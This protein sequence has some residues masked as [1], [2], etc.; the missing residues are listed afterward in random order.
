MHMSALNS[1]AIDLLGLDGKVPGVEVDA[2]G[3][4]TGIIKE[5][6][7]NIVRDAT[8]PDKAK[9]AKA[10]ALAT[11][12]AHSMGVTSVQDNGLAE[13]LSV[14]QAA[15]RSGKLGLRV[16]FNVPARELDPML[17][18]SISSGLGSNFLR[19]GGVKLFCDG[20]LGARTAALSE[21]YADDAGNRGEFMQGREAL[22]DVVAR[23][24]SADIQLV[25]HAIGDMGIEAAISS[26]ESALEGC[27]RRDH[28]H[29]IEHLEL[30]SPKHLR[31]MRKSKIIASMQP[32]FVGE[33]GGTNGMYYARL[34]EAR[35]RRNNP[36]KEVLSSGVRMVFGSDCMPF[37]PLYGIVSA[38]KAPHDAQR[39]TAEEAV[40][41]Y[42]REAAYASFE[43]ASKGTVS[44]GKLA[45]LAI[46]SADPFVDEGA[47]AGA[48]VLKTV[49]GGDV[50]YE[51][52]RAGE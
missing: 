27:P 5:S 10:L 31:R 49:V 13:H 24:N 21:P 30:P 7:V 20:A 1:K 40:A 41:A 25:V 17:R 33:W 44:V 2:G 45:D 43:E 47:L 37:S 15:E 23:A 42:T 9:N 32:N 46:L 3:R 4:P 12:R 36:F 34:G 39:I 18:L 51:R 52:P 26:V 14:Y 38:V 16:S 22:D 29:R 19:I 48:V 6:A 11:R 28:R 50:V 8:R 35:A